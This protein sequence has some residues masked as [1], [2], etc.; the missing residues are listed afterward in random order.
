[1]ILKTYPT[2]T[3]PRKK[4]RGSGIRDCSREKGVYMPLAVGQQACIRG[5]QGKKGIYLLKQG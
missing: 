4:A 3:K 5:C 2:V 1:M